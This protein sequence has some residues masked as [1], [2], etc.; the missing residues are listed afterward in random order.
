MCGKEEGGFFMMVIINRTSVVCLHKVHDV[1]NFVF[2]TVASSPPS[3]LSFRKK[4]HFK[5]YC[6]AVSAEVLAVGVAMC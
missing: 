5:A 1:N 3:S 6:Q 4:V 2:S